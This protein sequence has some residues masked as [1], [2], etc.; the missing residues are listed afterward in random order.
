MA[1]GRKVLICLGYLGRLP[2]GSSLGDAVRQV[3]YYFLT[4][5]LLGAA[6]SPSSASLAQ[7][8]SS[9]SVLEP[10][11]FAMHPQVPEGSVLGGFIPLPLD[12]RSLLSLPPDWKPSRRHSTK[13]AKTPTHHH[14][15]VASSA[16]EEGER[17]RRGRLIPVG[18]LHILVIP[19]INVRR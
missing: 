14:Q 18:A 3:S 2:G 5:T 11:L 8:T 6:W 4:W 7:F 10:T 12:T 19:V 17:V 1:Q 9:L 15:N 13:S 16:L